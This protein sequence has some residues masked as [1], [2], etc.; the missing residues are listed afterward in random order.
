MHLK[1]EPKASG[2]R[3]SSGKVARSTDIAC[4]VYSVPGIA[5]DAINALECLR[6][7]L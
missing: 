4:F 1:R 6:E 3:L 7:Q 5:G 2:A